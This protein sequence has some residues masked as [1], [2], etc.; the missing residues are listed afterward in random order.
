LAVLQSHPS[1]DPKVQRLAGFLARAA[2]CCLHAAL[3]GSTCAPSLI[4]SR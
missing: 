1:L 4:E 3:N 2:R